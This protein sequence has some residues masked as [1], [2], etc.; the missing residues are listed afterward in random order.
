MILRPYVRLLARTRLTSTFLLTC[1]SRLGYAALPLC[2]LFT[3]RQA[4]ESFSA[5]AVMVSVFALASLTMPVKARWADRFGQ[6]RVLPVLGLAV[7]VVLGLAAGMGWARVS[8]L[9]TWFAVSAVAG[10]AA[11]P[12]GPCMRAQWRRAAPDETPL[13]YGLDGAGE[14][15]VWMLGP[16]CAG[17]VL[18]HLPAWVALGMLAPMLLVGCLALGLGRLGALR[19]ARD[20]RP[21]RT[22]PTK[23]LPL[24]VLMLG[25]GLI[26][27]Q[28][29]TGIAARADAVGRLDLAGLA[30]GS[31]GLGAVVGGLVAGTK[32]AAGSWA[33]RLA[34]IFVALGCAAGAAA[35]SDFEHL[36]LG[37]FFC[38]GLFSGPV[39][40]TVYHAADDMVAE[41]HR[42]EASTWVSTMANVGAATGTATTGALVTVWGPV[43]G[44]WSAAA[45]AVAI[46]CGC[47][48][49]SLRHQAAPLRSGRTTAG[50]GKQAG[51]AGVRVNDKHS[52]S[53]RTTAARRR[54]E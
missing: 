12:L 48:V 52:Q 28:V 32:G 36:A 14:E 22:V 8:D 16:V 50:G 19:A 39:W 15:T 1:L 43:A 23:V 10:V 41:A 24:V 53:T 17:F 2:L 26:T 3:V 21:R 29:V 11:P 7:A 51:G 9:P 37:A 30:E 42:T 4:T 5:G 54:S 27:A 47:L 6:R 25:F 13:A 38:V 31:V 46:G 18:V 33:R 35:W 40:M 44:H 20:R 34:W 45:L 49:H